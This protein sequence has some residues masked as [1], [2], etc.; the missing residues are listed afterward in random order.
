MTLQRD[1]KDFITAPWTGADALLIHRTIM[2]MVLV[3]KGKKTWNYSNHYKKLKAEYEK[4]LQNK[5]FY[6]V[7]ES[8]FLIGMDAAV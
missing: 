3:K 1:L 6:L 8:Q 5:D 7:D 2:I 4:T